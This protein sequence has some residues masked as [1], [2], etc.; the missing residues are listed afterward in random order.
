MPSSTK[1]AGEGP[2][3]VGVAAS[4]WGTPTLFT[5]GDLRLQ[6]RLYPTSSVPMATRGWGAGEPT[7][8]HL[9]DVGL[10]LL[11]AWSGGSGS[12]RSPRLCGA[13]SWTY[14]VGHG[15]WLPAKAMAPLTSPKGVSIGI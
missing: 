10:G 15:S 11:L 3:R 4:L 14:G 7:I 2:A 12:L 1:Q 13:N 8:P 5:C 9:D 6:V